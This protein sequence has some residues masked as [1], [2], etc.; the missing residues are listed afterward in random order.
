M[1]QRKLLS[2]STAITQAPVLV[3]QYF[4]KLFVVCCNASLVGIGAIPS[5]ESRLV[6]FF[7][8]NLAEPRQHYLAYDPQ[9]YAFVQALHHWQHYVLHQDFVVYLDHEYRRNLNSPKKLIPRHASQSSFL[10]QFTLSIK[11]RSGKSNGVANA[12]SKRSYLLST[13]HNQEI[14]FVLLKDQYMSDPFFSQTV[15]EL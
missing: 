13:L 8:E 12:L 10:Q 1:K 15:K 7:N 4:S 5:K 14:S 9:Y 3:L 2:I 6:A 11:Y